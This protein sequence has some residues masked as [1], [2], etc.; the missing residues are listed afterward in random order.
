MSQAGQNVD[1][2]GL[3]R[4]DG[5][6]L[7]NITIQRPEIDR[8]R[9]AAQGSYEQGIFFTTSTFS[10]GAIDASIK[11]GAIPIVLLDGLAIVD[12]MIQRKIRV[13]STLMEIPAFAL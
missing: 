10:K 7:T 6:P 13:E 11:S 9:G 4:W 3:S 8:F 5:Q 2:S 12:L 1:A